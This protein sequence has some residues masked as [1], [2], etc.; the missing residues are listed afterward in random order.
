MTIPPC[1][2]SPANPRIVR[3]NSSIIPRSSRLVK[4]KSNSF[5]LGPRESVDTHKFSLGTICGNEW[6]FKL[7]TVGSNALT[8]DVK[9]DIVPP[10]NT[11]ALAVDIISEKT[12]EGSNRRYRSCI[13]SSTGE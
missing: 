9:G 2:T 7:S 3:P 1:L 12:T 10:A 5:P 11:T 13:P 4:S 8:Y 6:T